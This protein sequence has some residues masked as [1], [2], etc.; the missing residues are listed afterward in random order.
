MVEGAVIAKD[1][2][3]SRL[4]Q[5]EDGSAFSES[6]KLLFFSPKSDKKLI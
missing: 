6:Q 1:E 2:V 3:T 4:H 5:A